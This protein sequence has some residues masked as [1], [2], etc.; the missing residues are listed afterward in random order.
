MNA[1]AQGGNPLAQHD[2][3]INAAKAAGADRFV[4]SASH[5]AASA[6]SAFPPMRGSR[7][8]RKKP[9]AGRVWRGPRCAMASMASAASP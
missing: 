5:M 9:Q 8:N 3:A 2:T 1:G 6:A 4:Y 7:S